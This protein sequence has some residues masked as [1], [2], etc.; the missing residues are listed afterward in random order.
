VCRELSTLRY[1]V[2]ECYTEDG[3]RPTT[4]VVQARAVNHLSVLV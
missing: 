1:E 4:V 3:S 2:R